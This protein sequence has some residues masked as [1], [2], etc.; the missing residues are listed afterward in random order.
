MS[1]TPL[2]V[3]GP[4]RW[5]AEGVAQALRADVDADVRTFDDVAAL[6]AASRWP[7]A[8][9]VATWSAR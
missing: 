6:H 7:A 2:A 3:V 5:A 1:M 8:W 9:G 4:S